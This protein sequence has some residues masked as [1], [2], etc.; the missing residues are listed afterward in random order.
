MCIADPCAAAPCGA[1]GTCTV[2][3]ADAFACTCT[4]NFAGSLCDTCATGYAGA[5]CSDCASGFLV[6]P[7]APG[8]CTADLCTA[9]ACGGRGACAMEAAG[10]FSC[11]CEGNY[12]GLGCASCVAGY[13]GPTCE[14]CAA[15]AHLEGGICV[16]DRV[17]TGCAVRPALAW[18]EPGEAVGVEG[19]V[20]VGELTAAAGRLTGITAQVCWR[21]GLIVAPVDLEDLVCVPAE[22]AAEAAGADA[23]LAPALFPTAGTWRYLVAFS[24]DGGATWTACDTEG[25]VA[26]N[27]SAG[28]ASVFNVPNGGFEALDSPLT[29]WST[30]SGLDVEAETEA[31]HS[32]LRAARL[33]RTTTVNSDADFVAIAVPVTPGAAY[34]ISMWFFDQDPSARGNVIYTWYDANGAP[35]GATS[36]GGTYSADLPT[37]QNITRAVTAPATAASIRISTR[38]YAQSG[39]AATGGSFVVDDVALIP[40]AL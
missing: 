5:A 35:L 18:G 10:V 40:S 27:V 21:S 20:H 8:V 12:A 13:A 14:D 38:V 7:T 11:A 25:P 16:T 15:G 19:E 22:Y 31:V 1:H 30:D 28:V 24:G 29:G 33:T 9:E 23:Y 39:G 34:T 3:G 37:W 2:L 26:G 32:G 36:Y 6:D 17:I 4:G